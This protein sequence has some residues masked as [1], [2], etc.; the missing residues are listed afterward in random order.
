MYLFINSERM[1]GCVAAGEHQQDE[2]AFVSLP[3]DVCDGFDGT[4]VLLCGQGMGGCW[5]A[6]DAIVPL[7]NCGRR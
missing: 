2:I 3:N 5:K 4:D 1:V 6:R 7:S